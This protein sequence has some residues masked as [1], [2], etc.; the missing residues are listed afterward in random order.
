MENK[1]EML[2][3]IEEGTTIVN[4]T[5]PKETGKIDQ[6]C[7]NNSTMINDVSSDG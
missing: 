6:Q 5:V 7:Y 1:N 2:F 4:L 3:T